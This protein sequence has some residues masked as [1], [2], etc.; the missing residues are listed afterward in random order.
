[1]KINIYRVPMKQYKFYCEKIHFAKFN[2]I[3]IIISLYY[4]Y[5]RIELT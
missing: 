3:V 1:M 4:F 2:H 5:I